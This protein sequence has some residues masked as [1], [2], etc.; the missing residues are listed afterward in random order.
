M[1]LFVSF[2]LVS[3]I[4]LNVPV[5][6]ALAEVQPLAQTP[7]ALLRALSLLLM[8]IFFLIFPDGHFVPRWT[9]WL[10]AAWIIYTVSFLFIPEIAPPTGL[11]SLGSPL[12]TASLA[13][14][15]C[16]LFGCVAAQVYRY[17]T[18]SSAS[19]RRQTKW[20]VFGF[21]LF[22]LFGFLGALVV[23]LPLVLSPGSPNPLSVL[24][25][26]TLLLVSLTMPPLFIGIA[27]L[28]SRLW[29]IDILIRRTVTYTILTALLVAVFVTSIIFLQQVFAALTGTAQNELVTV[30]S[31]LAIAAL[32]VPLRNRVQGW[33]DR[34]FYR[35][36][37]D[38]QQVLQEFSETGRDETDLERLT[39]RLI[40]VVNET[41]QPR[42]VSIW[43]KRT[44]E[45]RVNE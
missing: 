16:Y 3:Y 12:R 2:A 34:R 19:E 7:Y 15:G 25:G 45:R 14:S 40:A 10:A 27:I 17:R 31:T 4:G 9:R 43:L 18:T 30:L 32:F 11:A 13:L 8:G 44:M 35:K 21:A 5:V 20:A 1:A 33:I 24:V 6:P 42:S 39:G 23:I 38:A 29:D 36:K 41:M 22:V 26:V 37:Y 28:H